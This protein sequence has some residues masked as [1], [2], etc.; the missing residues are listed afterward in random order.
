MQSGSAPIG[1][2]G[3][4]TNQKKILI[5]FERYEGEQKETVLPAYPLGRYLLRERNLKYNISFFFY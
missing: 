3:I 2:E 4:F 1:F 5:G